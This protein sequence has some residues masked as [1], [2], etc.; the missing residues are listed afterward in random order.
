MLSSKKTSQQ[1][2]K[3]P[4]FDFEVDDKDVQD[5]VYVSGW[6]LN[7]PYE[8]IKP[9]FDYKILPVCT[10][11]NIKNVT[12]KF[13]AYELPRLEM[14]DNNAVTSFS[15]DDMMTLHFN[16]IEEFHRYAGDSFRVNGTLEVP[17]KYNMIAL[18]TNTE[19]TTDEGVTKEVQALDYKF[20]YR[21]VS[22]V[23]GTVE[24]LNLA[25]YPERGVT[26]FEKPNYQ[27]KYFNQTDSI[28]DAI[29]IDHGDL[30]TF[31]KE[32][33]GGDWHIVAQ[34]EGYY[35]DGRTFTV[36]NDQPTHLGKLLF[37]RGLNP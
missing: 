5:T 13:Y 33:P 8:R 27:L 11:E 3:T 9:T 4:A 21:P 22:I 20:I 35:S 1:F 36:E 17:L 19:Y 29:N 25:K 32:F 31:S 26:E 10:T 14:D 15:W 28:E 30:F 2:S 34:K 12:Y 37:E 24:I 23:R 18:Y 6:L 16:V 7:L